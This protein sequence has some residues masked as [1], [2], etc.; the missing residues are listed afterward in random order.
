V[1][2]EAAASTNGIRVIAFGDMGASFC[3]AAWGCLKSSA[4]TTASILQ[5]IASDEYAM[6]LH[7]GDISYALNY[8]V[9]WEEWFDE[10]EPIATQVP[11]MVGLGNHEYDHF[12][13]PFKPSWGNYGND[14]NGECGVPYRNRFHMPSG[15]LDQGKGKAEDQK[16][17]LLPVDDTW[18]YSFDYGNVHWVMMSSEHDFTPGSQQYQWLENDLASVNRTLTPWVVFNGHR[19]MYCSGD[20]PSDYKMALNLQFYLEDLLY[21]YRVDLCLWGH[22]HS[23]ER[24]CPVYRNRCVTETTQKAYHKSQDNYLA[25]VHVVIG[26][27]GAL[28][29]P[30]WMNPQPE[31]SIFRDGVRYGYS[32][33]TV[34]NATALEFKYLEDVTRTVMDTFWLFK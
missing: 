2:N 33:V 30:A 6:V 32:T 15:L 26:M 28:L 29:S 23:Y 25:P 8:G 18:W 1:G 7:I 3:P 31:W 14:S 17:G 10:I 9:T 34:H 13:Q 20:Y 5:E 22:Y 24:T 11:W 21:K 4:Q 19:P 12:D 16:T 27:A